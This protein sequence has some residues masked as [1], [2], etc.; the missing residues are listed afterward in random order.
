MENNME[1]KMKTQ[2]EILDKT[3]KKI[4]IFFKN[5]QNP[6]MDIKEFNTLIETIQSI[7]FS[8]KCEDLGQNGGIQFLIDSLNV[9]CYPNLN[10]T[11]EQ[12]L[13]LLVSLVVF[14]QNE[15]NMKSFIALDGIQI[16]SK[17]VV[18]RIE[19]VRIQQAFLEMMLDLTTD[20]SQLGG[21]DSMRFNWFSA[22]TK[23]I[24]RILMA[25]VK[26][27][28]NDLSVMTQTF[29]IMKKLRFNRVSPMQFRRFLSVMKI[30]K[31]DRDLQADG[32]EICDE[33][34]RHDNKKADILFKYG[35]RYL[36][37]VFMAMH[38]FT[39]DNRIRASG[40]K[41]LNIV[42]PLSPV[43]DENAL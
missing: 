41:I 31:E 14:F 16:V 39:E 25:N 7:G 28:K 26:F 37:M 40:M 27:H 1:N 3:L 4:I 24:L 32:L 21:K 20:N 22:E 43:T 36:G 35:S 23:K 5:K 15:K 34:L 12:N 17:M 42:R 8:P 33:I 29:H 13:D 38:R 10:Y 2:D 9:K 19:N 6:Y 30:H 11:D 18:D